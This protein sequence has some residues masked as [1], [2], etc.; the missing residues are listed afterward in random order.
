MLSRTADSMFWL[1]RYIERMDCL[2]RLLEAAQRM[3]G[4][5]DSDEEWRSA[6]VA[7]GQD[8][9]FFEKYEKADATNVARYLAC[10]RDNPSSIIMCMEHARSNAR[11]MRTALTR[12]MWDAVNE[13][14]LEVRNFDVAQFSAEQLPRTLDWVKERATRFNGA[15]ISTMLRND[16]YYFTRLGTFIER[17]DNTARI[18]DVKYHLLLPGW[19]GVGGMLD[20]YQWTSILQAVSAVRAYRWV[21][22]DK[23]TPLNV[24]DLLIL[25]PEMPRSLRAC[26]DEIVDALAHLADFY[27]GRRGEC[28]RLAGEIAAR[29]RYGRVEAI[30]RSGLHE[31]LVDTLDRTADLGEEVARFYMR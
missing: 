23:V 13:T 6:I 2:A 17:A 22:K 14:W 4:H 25:R 10:D 11:A 3:S 9:D 19:S 24:A 20:Y 7:A 31:F 16:V 12:D 21:Y 15:Y 29:L 26:Y 8:V 27:G 28:H 30:F 1:A 5:D 18:L